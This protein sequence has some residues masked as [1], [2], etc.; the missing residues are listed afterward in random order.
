[1][2]FQPFDG[3]WRR[4]YTQ[5]RRWM[6]DV[7]VISGSARGVP[8]SAV[9][10]SGTRPISDRVKAALFDTLQDRIAGA[11]V[12]DLFAGTG[13]V[14]IEALS[15]GADRVVF[16]ENY[17]KAI[18]TIRGN[19]ERTR[20]QGGA[21]LVRTDVFRFLLGT[22]EPFDFIYIAPPQYLALWKRALLAI[23]ASPS[24]LSP[25]GLAVVQVFPKEI[26]A[27]QL[28]ALT[29]IDQRK[30]GSTLLSFYEMVAT[31]RG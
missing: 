25:A 20:L 23:D 22:P 1:M 18:Q 28:S 13:S 17:A 15:R 6:R 11:H 31:G 8:L 21:H 12:L 9:P 16:V 3:L 14:G 27:L 5:P 2:R 19:L 29:C 10:G 24:W 7:R 30:Y 26:E 4:A